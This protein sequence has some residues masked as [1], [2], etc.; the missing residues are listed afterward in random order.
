MW[1]DR[2]GPAV[3]SDSPLRLFPGI[4]PGCNAL[5][6]DTQGQA[7]PPRPGETSLFWAGVQGCPW[8]Q[9]PLN[10]LPQR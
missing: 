5:L 10:S 2:G 3:L 8:L 6:S 7:L 4:K 1:Q 9:V